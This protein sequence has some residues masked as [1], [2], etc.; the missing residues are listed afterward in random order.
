MTSN[1]PWAAAAACGWC[2]LLGPTTRPRSDERLDR[3][4][5]TIHSDAMRSI[6]AS[7]MAASHS[8]LFTL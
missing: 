4:F 8:I 2:R 5:V 3:S 1:R 7:G 6:C